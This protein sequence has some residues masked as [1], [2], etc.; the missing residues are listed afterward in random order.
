MWRPLTLTLL[1]VWSTVAVIAILEDMKV[2]I[3]SQWALGLIAAYFL[4]LGIVRRNDAQD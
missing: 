4:A 1:C 2:D 3:Y